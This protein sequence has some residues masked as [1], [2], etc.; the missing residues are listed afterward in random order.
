MVT[1]IKPKIDRWDTIRSSYLLL[2][3]P[4]LLYTIKSHI[5]L[6][7]FVIMSNMVMISVTNNI[8]F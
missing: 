8:I 7:I 5:F 1:V 2:H 6:P 3:C 4:K